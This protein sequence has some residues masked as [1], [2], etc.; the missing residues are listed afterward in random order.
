[1]SWLE[2]NLTSYLQQSFF[3]SFKS[4]VRAPLIYWNHVVVINFVRLVTSVIKIRMYTQTYRKRCVFFFWEN[5]I[6]WHGFI[7]SLYMAQVGWWAGMRWGEIRPIYQRL[8]SSG[9]C[10]QVTRESFDISHQ[11]YFFLLTFFIMKIFKHAL[12]CQELFGEHPYTHLIGPTVNIYLWFITNLSNPSTYPLFLHYSVLY[13]DV[14]QCELQTSVHS[15]L[16]TLGC[17]CWTDIRLGFLFFYCEVKFTYS[18][19]YKFNEYT[20]VT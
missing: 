12:K 4:E 6:Q 8:N 13:L 16:N 14:F 7:R 2:N 15:L 17:K 11:R 10:F 18:V 5:S 20:C 1:M 3:T 9:L 19:A